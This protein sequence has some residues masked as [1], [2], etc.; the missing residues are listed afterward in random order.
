MS[1]EL[2]AQ[3]GAYPSCSGLLVARGRGSSVRV[4]FPCVRVDWTGHL[5]R[6]CGGRGR[7][8][9]SAQVSVTHATGLASISTLLQNIEMMINTRGV[10]DFSQLIYYLGC[11]PLSEYKQD[12]PIIKYQQLSFSPSRFH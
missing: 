7:C 1:R 6:L 2:Q 4:A 9:T 8:C 3:A 5:D 11:V 10:S 12:I